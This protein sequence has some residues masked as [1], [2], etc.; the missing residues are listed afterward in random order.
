MP[1]WGASR[2]AW[3]V[4]VNSATRLNATTQR[5]AHAPFWQPTTP[6]YPPLTLAR[7]KTVTS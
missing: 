2:M 1:A 5:K 6:K 7:A 3:R 4:A